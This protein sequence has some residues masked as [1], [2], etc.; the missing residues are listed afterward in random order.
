MTVCPGHQ[1]ICPFVQSEA[2]KLIRARAT[3]LHFDPSFRLDPVSRQVVHDV[4][5]MMAR[6]FHLIARAD[7]NDRHALRLVEEW[8]RILNRP[9]CLARILPSDDDMVTDEK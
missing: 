7:F 5:D 6:G 3:K 2:D 4:I 1:Q 9:P 8:Q